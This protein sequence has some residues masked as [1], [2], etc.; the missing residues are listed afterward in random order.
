MIAV[1]KWYPIV[2]L[3]DTYSTIERKEQSFHNMYRMS[4]PGFE[5]VYLDGGYVGV[6]SQYRVSTSGRN[7]PKKKEKANSAQM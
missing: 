1:H 7:E 4:V 6:E 2:F 3:Y 5:N